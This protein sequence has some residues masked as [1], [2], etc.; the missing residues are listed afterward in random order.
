MAR[1]PD[2]FIDD[3]LARTDIVEVVGTRVPLKRQGKEYAARCPFHDERSASFT[4]SPTK[5]FYH[6]FGCGA[7]GTAISFLMNYDRLEFLDA[8]DELARRVGME[9]PRDTR[10]NNE[11]SGTRDLYAALDAAAQFFRR[12]LAGSDKARAYVARREIDP[13]IVERYAI[14][15]APDGFSG[16]RDALGT[17]PRRMQLLERAGLFSKN[18]KG[19]VY[20]KFRDRLMFPIHDRRGRTIA[21]GGRVIDPEDSPKYLNSPETALFHKGRE[22]Y[23]LW[24]AKQANAKLERLVVVEGYM[25][26]VALAQY[27]VS[28]AVATLGT[29][30]TPDHAELLFRNAPDVYFCFDGDRAGRAAAWKALESVLPRMKDGRQAL[31]LFLPEGEDP[32]TIVRKDGA[33]GFD[34]RLREAMPLSE[35]FFAE[36]SK[37]VN[38]GTLDGKAR[39]AER[40]KPL[41]AQIPEG[42]FG[43]LMKQ[44]LAE[45]TGLGARA[46]QPAP[47]AQVAPGKGVRQ[48]PIRTAIAA[49]LQQPSVALS[50]ALP[51]RFSTLQQA[52]VRL[53]TDMVLLVHSR[54]DITTGAI[55]EH[56]SQDEQGKAL[57]RLAMAPLVDATVATPLDERVLD[58]ADK[59]EQTF[60]DAIARLNIQAMQARRE[61]LQAR[62]ATLDQ[63]E[64]DELRALLRAT[65]GL[66]SQD[67]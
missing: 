8:V 4:V 60:R 30:T 55:L 51:L 58:D 10:Q 43:D 46:E 16:L 52:G 19:S 38:L 7:H 23:G 39:L 25:D 44:R 11:D 65:S 15:Y 17:D 67:V 9:V 14:G 2:S 54:P 66:P 24:Q 64:K 1:L 62:L 59:R 28:Q 48:S 6:C 26:V 37:D 12:Q 33:A 31:F 29:A 63:A 56:F 22:L 5:Q 50:L 42:A 61:E 20:D 45:L 27:G 57:P 41:L 32:D 13:A 53:L 47:R 35:F 18:D 21:F 40:C 34:M 49:L 36:M 3:L